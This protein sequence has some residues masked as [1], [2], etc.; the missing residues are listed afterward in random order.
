MYIIIGPWLILELKYLDLK[1]RQNFDNIYRQK[2]VKQYLVGNEIQLFKNND[3]VNK[4][5]KKFIGISSAI[6]SLDYKFEN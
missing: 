6:L 4:T 1:K 3:K 2:F 5:M